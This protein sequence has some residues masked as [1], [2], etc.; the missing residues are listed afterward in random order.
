MIMVDSL[1]WPLVGGDVTCTCAPNQ[2]ATI[3]SWLMRTT[4][5]QTAKRQ[6][7][8]SSPRKVIFGLWAVIAI[9]AYIYSRFVHSV[10]TSQPIPV[11]TSAPTA[12]RPFKCD[13]RTLCSQMTSCDEA[14]Y[15]LAHCPN[16]QMDGDHDGEPC[17]QQW[18]N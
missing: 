6:G 13:G 9:G 18:C 15:F 3:R 11:T 7:R 12:A 5:R 4:Q 17:E 16:T 2:L 10:P 14:R 8:A 1:N